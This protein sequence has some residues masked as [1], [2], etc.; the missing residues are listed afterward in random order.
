MIEFSMLYHYTA[1]GI[2]QHH[3]LENKVMH[4]V[5]S[6]SV[7][8]RILMTN[9]LHLTWINSVRNENMKLIRF[10]KIATLFHSSMISMARIWR[11]ISCK[12]ILS[13]YFTSACTRQATTGNLKCIVTNR[14]FKLECESNQILDHLHRSNRTDKIILYS[15]M[16]T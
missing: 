1:P 16:F 11:T 4:G 10:L 14:A 13:R 3:A 7:R 12:F 15:E 8:T 2:L 9:I 6:A 5:K